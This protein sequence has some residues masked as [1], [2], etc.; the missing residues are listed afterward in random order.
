MMN[1]HTSLYNIWNI[2][3][4]IQVQRKLRLFS[5]ASVTTADE[6]LDRVICL[7]LL[8][9]LSLLISPKGVLLFGPF[10]IYVIILQKM[11]FY[12]IG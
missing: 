3:D 12:I 10:I 11:Y 7:S 1:L 4:Q 2:S 9:S 5:L 6:L 8:S